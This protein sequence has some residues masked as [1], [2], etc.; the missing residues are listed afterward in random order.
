MEVQIM[1]SP[2]SY[3]PWNSAPGD[4]TGMAASADGAFHAFWIDNRT[5][6]GELYS[7]RITVE[8]SAD[9]PEA[10]F[11]PL[12][13]I[14]SAL[15]AQY[16]SS[17]WDPR[18]GILS[19]EHRFLNTSTDTIFGPLRLR[20]TRL[21]SDLGIP[22]LLFADGRKGW[23]GSVIDF[24]STIA[25][26]G[27]AP[28]AMTATQRLQVKLDDVRDWLLGPQRGDVLHVYMKAYGIRRGATPAKTD[29]SP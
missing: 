7:S 9:R 2:R 25:S 4:Y 11:T 17:A 1:V 29:G 6:V 15:E 22:S 5:G 24:P 12:K 8:G 28:G 10:Q 13:N 18:T 27:L 23:A 20:I 19:W 16:V 14:S 3:Y 26:N 21:E